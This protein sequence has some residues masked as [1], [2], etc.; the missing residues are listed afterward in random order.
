MKTYAEVLYKIK[1]G[2][3]I[4]GLTGYT[5]SGCTTASGILRRDSKPDLPGI[6][7]LENKPD[8]RRYRKLKIVWS[9]LGWEKF[10]DIEVSRIIFMFAIHRALQQNFKHGQLAQLRNLAL[11]HKTKL[12][13][14]EF[15]IKENID[16]KKDQV[17]KKLIKAYKAAKPLYPKFKRRCKYDLATFIEVMQE[18]GDEIRMYGHVEPTR[19][20]IQN[21]RTCL[22]YPRHC[23]A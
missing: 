3:L 2:F 6:E 13:G 4:L 12:E 19:K 21:Q 10:T 8:E 5:G 15:L 14:I 11:P 18:F 7:S 23:A 1:R 16:A 17:A 20:K 9:E 22:Y